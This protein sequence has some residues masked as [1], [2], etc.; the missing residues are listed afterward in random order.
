VAERAV[1]M[2]SQQL[3][4][5]RDA[6]TSI[7]GDLAA[8]RA[9]IAEIDALRRRAD[10]VDAGLAARSDELRRLDQAVAEL[11]PLAA[12][13]EALEVESGWSA[14]APPPA[15]AHAPALDPRVAE[16][17]ARLDAAGRREAELVARVDALEA[18]R[19]SSPGPARHAAEGQAA[20]EGGRDDL[21]RIKG[22]G[23]AFDRALRALGVQSYREIAAWTPDDVASI[24][25]RI[26]ARPERIVKEGWIASARELAEGEA[27]GVVRR[28]AG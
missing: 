24:A 16:L 6:V 4:R 10:G 3:Q 18:A 9:A 13:V 11:G 17:E 8:A 25:A 15:A 27:P 21:R 2:Q 20:G 23:P 5:L 14:P 22:I 7:E 1:L 12:R 19:A 28:S 26:G